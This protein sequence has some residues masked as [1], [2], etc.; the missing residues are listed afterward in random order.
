MGT[1][2]AD[3]EALAIAG[4]AL[5]AQIRQEMSRSYFDS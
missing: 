1:S 4:A 3:E 5:K 2:V